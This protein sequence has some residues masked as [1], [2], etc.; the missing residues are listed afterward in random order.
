VLGTHLISHL[1]TLIKT[2]VLGNAGFELL[3]F[4]EGLWVVWKDV[5]A[6]LFIFGNLDTAIVDAIIQ[7]VR[8]HLQD[9]SKL[10]KGEKTGD[11]TRV[12]LTALLKNTVAQANGFD[13]TG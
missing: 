13:G 3:E 6:S 12:G 2:Q 4:L 11:L 9:L 10:G 8:G 5:Q 1:D 7:P